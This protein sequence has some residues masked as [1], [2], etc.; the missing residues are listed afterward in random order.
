M[1]DF[2][3]NPLA[4][5]HVEKVDRREGD[6]WPGGDFTG[7]GAGWVLSKELAMTNDWYTGGLR[8]LALPAACF[9]LLAR[10][11]LRSGADIYRPEDI[12]RF[13]EDEFIDELL[14]GEDNECILHIF[15]PD[16]GSFRTLSEKSRADFLIPSIRNLIGYRA[17]GRSR[18]LR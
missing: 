11:N 18:R 13:F 14:V 2:P 10:A 9:A 1:Y 8:P 4:R 7:N 3:V 15:S 6:T 16:H 12:Q 5:A 17:S